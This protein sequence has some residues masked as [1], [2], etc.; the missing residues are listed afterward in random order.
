M[1][2]VLN[3]T[4]DDD[5]VK[6]TVK[7]QLAAIKPEALQDA[8]VGAIKNYF[9]ENKY[10]VERDF[11]CKKAVARGDSLFWGIIWRIRR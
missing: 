1:Q 9:T 8:L 10:D 7:D 6:D 4:V 3:L 11:L 5:S 2:L